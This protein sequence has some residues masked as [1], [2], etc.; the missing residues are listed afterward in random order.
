LKRLFMTA[1][2]RS[3]N[4]AK[5]EKTDQEIDS[6][7]MDNQEMYG[8]VA[9]EYKCAKAVA[10]KV[11]VPF[12][13][14]LSVVYDDDVKQIQRSYLETTNLALDDKSAIKV[15]ALK[16]AAEMS[17][18]TNIITYQGRTLDAKNMAK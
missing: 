13:I 9:H 16:K 18:A 10:D 8:P 14:I 1:T 2:P 12:K 17:G 7:S 6:D 11:I 5:S 15:V 4:S 3:R